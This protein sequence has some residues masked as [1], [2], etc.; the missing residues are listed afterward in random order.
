[1]KILY[2]SANPT[3]SS[4]ANSGPGVHIREVIAA[5]REQG[6]EVLPVII[7]DTIVSVQQKRSNKYLQIL[8]RISKLFIPAVIWRT[9][10]ELRLISFD[11][12]LDA[13]LRKKMESFKP[14]FVYERASHLQLSGVRVA[15]EKKITYLVEINAPFLDE[16]KS[17]ERAESLITRKIVNF[18]KSLIHFSEKV[19]VVSS[20]LKDYY[21]KYTNDHGKILVVPNCVNEKS[22]VVKKELKNNLQQKY[23]LQNK[24]V[25]GFVGS[26]FPY[27]GVDILIEAF[28]EIHEKHN[29]VFLLIVGDGQILEELGRKVEVLNLSKYV[30]FTGSVSHDEV[31]TYIDLMDITVMAKSNWYGSPVKIFEYGAMGK[32][33]IGP[34]T[35][36]VNDVMIDGEDGLLIEPNKNELFDAINKLLN[37]EILRKKLAFNFQSKVLEKYTWHQAVFNILESIKIK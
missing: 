22:L 34:N 20:A 17:F 27:H 11:K 7:G 32:P 9:I 8:K 13:M 6:H 5:M 35:I 29:N 4:K 30:V 21:A 31:Y 12:K 36:P 23:N 26:I 28:A 2:Y 25:I 10:K 1:M 24:I 14:D 33:I 18:E 19:F 15:L 16:V 37:D 3:I